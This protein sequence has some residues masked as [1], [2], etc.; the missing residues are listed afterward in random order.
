MP[1]HSP[2]DLAM[3]CFAG[4]DGTSAARRLVVCISEEPA[5]VVSQS[6]AGMHGLADRPALPQ[7]GGLFL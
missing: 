1:Q 4:D 6:Y 2:A 3:L 5:R 7:P